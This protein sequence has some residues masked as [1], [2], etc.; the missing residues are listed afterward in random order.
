MLQSLFKVIININILFIIFINNFEYKNSFFSYKLKLKG[1]SY[2]IIKQK[3][4]NLLL[5]AN[6]DNLNVFNK[7]TGGRKGFFMLFQ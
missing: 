3:R 7:Y 1:F 6:Y 4:T 5:K 2:K